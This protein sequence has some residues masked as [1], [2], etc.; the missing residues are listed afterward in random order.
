MPKT[1]TFKTKKGKPTN[2]LNSYDFYKSR[3]SGRREMAFSKEFHE[4]LSERDK[5]LMRGYAQRVV[6]EQKAFRHNNP[7]YVRKT[8]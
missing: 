8:H 3:Y 6:E 5:N 1:K 4:N 7:T 2:I